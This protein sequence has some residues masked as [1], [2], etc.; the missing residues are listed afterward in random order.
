MSYTIYLT[1]L[2]IHLTSQHYF[3]INTLFYKPKEMHMLLQVQIYSTRYNVF[4]RLHNISY[5]ATTYST[6]K[7][8]YFTITFTLLT[9]LLTYLQF[10]LQ[11]KGLILP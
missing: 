4:H 10:I 1:M 2:R 9:Y 7:N 6:R 8:N 5:K 3:T 11:S